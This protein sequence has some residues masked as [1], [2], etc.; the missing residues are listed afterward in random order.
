MKLNIIYT[1]ELKIKTP[2]RSH[3]THMQKVKI[4]L[5]PQI[6]NTNFSLERRAKESHSLLIEMQNEWLL[7]KRT[8]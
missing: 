1:R 3:D 8:W 6:G 5:H 7:W 2:I 4:H